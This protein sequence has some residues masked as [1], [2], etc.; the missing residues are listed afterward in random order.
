MGYANRKVKM[1]RHGHFYTLA[2]KLVLLGVKGS[3]DVYFPVRKRISKRYFLDA[4]DGTKVSS[5][6]K[7]SAIVEMCELLGVSSE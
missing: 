1:R 3:H 4:P 2:L 6:S 7:I 5:W